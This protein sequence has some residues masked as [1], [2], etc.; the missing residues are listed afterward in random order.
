MRGSAGR[1]SHC[2]VLDFVPCLC[3]VSY[4][5]CI[6]YCIGRVAQVMFGT[7]EAM[8]GLVA[9]RQQDLPFLISFALSALRWA[10][11]GFMERSLGIIVV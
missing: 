11:A 2:G 5:S 8:F 9:G 7:Q 3:V 6:E 1:A 10:C 4:V